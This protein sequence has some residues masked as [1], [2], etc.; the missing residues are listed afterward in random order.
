MAKFLG[1][2]TL[3]LADAIVLPINT[4]HYTVQLGKYVDGY[5]LTERL[6]IN[7]LL[8]HTAAWSGSLNTAGG[9]SCYG[10]LEGYFKC[11]DA[12][13]ITKE[14]YKFRT[15]SGIIGSVLW[16]SPPSLSS[17]LFSCSSLRSCLPLSLRSNTGAL[18]KLLNIITASLMS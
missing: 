15:P 17:F 1:L 4:T 14:L 2:Q 6:P 5:V 18:I 10:T 8:M 12:K 16:C 9:L 7:L 3:R 11:V 13:D